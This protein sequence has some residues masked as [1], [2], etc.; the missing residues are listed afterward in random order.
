MEYVIGCDVGSQSTKAMLVAL[1][2][3]PVGEASASYTIDYPHALWAE[4]P[5]SRWI[6]ALALAI[7]RVLATSGVTAAQVRGLG[8]AT[9][10]DGVVPIDA[11]G[12][13]LRPAILWMD[14]RAG[15]QCA[16]ARRG[17]D[18]ARALQITGLNLDAS[19][20]APKIRWIA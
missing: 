12:A 7:R 11:R 6:E 10:V 8:L 14:R 13:P 3:A 16:A 9:Q 2:G 5:V 15:D 20:V 18:H 1:D 19:H 17:M 4:Q